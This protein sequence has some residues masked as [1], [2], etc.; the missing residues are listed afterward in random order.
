MKNITM[1]YSG[2]VSRRVKRQFLWLRQGA[3]GGVALF[4]LCPAFA[5]DYIVFPGSVMQLTTINGQLSGGTGTTITTSSYSLRMAGGGLT[6]ASIDSSCQVPVTVNGYTGTAAVGGRNDIVVGVTG[7][8]SGAKVNIG[9][10]SAAVSGKQNIYSIAGSW[11]KYGKIS[12][13]TASAASLGRNCL[14]PSGAPS[15]GSIYYT[16]AA[17]A[18]AGN[19]PATLNL[20]IWAYI[21]PNVPYGTY[22]LTQLFFRQGVSTS[23]AALVSSKAILN[24]GDRLIVRAPPCS[25]GVGKSTVTFTNLSTSSDMSASV[26]DSLS[27]NCTGSSVSAKAYVRATGITGT[28]TADLYGLG[29]INSDTKQSKVDGTGIIV[30][31]E[32]GNSRAKNCSG[33]REASSVLFAPQSLL[34]GYYVFDL[35]AT[36][37]NIAIPLEWYACTTSKTV[38]GKYTGAVTLGITYQ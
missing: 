21:G 22:N 14:Y 7:T 15:S 8:S 31:G 28:A 5:V 26:G 34:P 16:G 37:R 18:N 32:L 23:T 35:S 4:M 17:N 11:D 9:T 19:V 12:S 27:V 29:L 25:L 33:G 13:S 38:P 1:P 10:T 2:L 30:R 6:T 20:N 3:V 36:S 24:P